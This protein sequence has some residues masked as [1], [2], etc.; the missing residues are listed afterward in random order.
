MKLHIKLEG[1]L[2]EHGDTHICIY[3]HRNCLKVNRHQK[4]SG[5][6][7]QSRTSDRWTRGTH[8]PMCNLEKNICHHLIFK[9]KTQKTAFINNRQSMEQEVLDQTYAGHSR[10]FSDDDQWSVNLLPWAV[11]SLSYTQH[12]PKLFENIGTSLVKLFWLQ[13]LSMLYF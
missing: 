6:H 12:W 4:C 13:N 9:K 8:L 3:M 10:G 7:L 5:F 2:E 11:L 1:T